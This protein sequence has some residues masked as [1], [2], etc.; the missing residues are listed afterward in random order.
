MTELSIFMLKNKKSSS[1]N[2]FIDEKYLK[3]SSTYLFENAE[4]INK[5]NLAIFPL[6]NQLR[7]NHNV[8]G[9][10]FILQER[11]EE[12]RWLKSVNFFSEKQIDYT[13][14]NILNKP[15]III[16]TTSN[17]IYAISYSYGYT[18]LN[19]EY[20]V[21]DFGLN[22]A[23]KELNLNTIK[24]VKNTN[25][26]DTLYVS[27]FSSNNK[28][29]LNEISTSQSTPNIV[30]EI[31]GEMTIRFTAEDKNIKELKIFA[32]S[33]DSIKINGNFSI[34]QDI[35]PILKQLGNTYR[36]K[37]SDR[38]FL[39]KEI[40]TVPPTKEEHLNKRFDDRLSKLMDTF[41]KNSNEFKINNL[42]K[43]FVD[44]PLNKVKNNIEDLEFRIHSICR[45]G[46]Y[47][48]FF[49]NTQEEIFSRIFSF[50]LKNNVQEFVE[51][52]KTIKV[53]IK[54]P[55][56]DFSKDISIGSLF[57]CLYME[58]NL[59][60]EKYILYQGDW[61]SVNKNVWR[62]TKDFVNNISSEVHGID[63]NEFNN[64]D[65]NEGDYNIKISQLDSNN[66]LICVDKE[67]FGNQNLDGGFGSYNING[68]SQIEPCDIL[69]V[70][71]DSALFCHVKREKGS[72]ALSHLLSQARAS[73]ILLKKSEDF[74]NHINSVIKKE[75]C[76][77]EAIL[78]NE[79]N[80][81]RPIVILGIIVSE[82]KVHKKNSKAFPVLF[83]LNLVALVNA[84]SLEKF[85][86]SLVKIPEKKV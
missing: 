70:N 33:K 65:T 84:L 76:E 43:L 77:S 71:N 28:I 59:N 21:P 12:V 51:K 1:I 75:S 13:T 85:E 15:L 37:R 80:L 41:K 67:N 11:Q 34:Q 22:I 86:V 29:N 6:D 45:P 50:F 23:R 3:H 4:D 69:K 44:I 39:D 42:D 55:N 57:S 53:S 63:F 78:L 8:T 82:E 25:F 10:I 40:L 52:L 14:P 62:E 7:S 49:D 79:T 36:K 46:E 24:R 9:K 30:D 17:S 32:S 66:G 61:L 38:T 74:V 60:S 73:C 5:F 19:R 2:S 81:K 68:R 26:A 20:V 56:S 16:K 31:L 83:S 18:L 58:L 72:S 48:N 27:N 64:D 54:N 35:V 47:F